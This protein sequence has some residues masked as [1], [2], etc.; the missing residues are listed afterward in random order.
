ML[1]IFID[2]LGAFTHIQELKAN[3][4]SVGSV[5]S[6]GNRLLSKE[7]TKTLPIFMRGGTTYGHGKN[8]FCQSCSEIAGDKLISLLPSRVCWIGNSRSGVNKTPYVMSNKK[9]AHL[10]KPW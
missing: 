10:L 4:S 3:V 6:V 7:L 1:K 2:G 9:G 5:G 8:K